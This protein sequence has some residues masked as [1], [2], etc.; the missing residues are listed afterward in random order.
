MIAGVLLAVALTG[1]H[2]RIGPQDKFLTEWAGS[3]PH[4]LHASNAVAWQQLI[5][6]LG[7]RLP[8]GTNLHDLL[9]ARPFEDK[10]FGP[11]GT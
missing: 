4:G 11:V 2:N 5:N 8:E 10:A 7:I 9:G 3:E 6:E 1:T